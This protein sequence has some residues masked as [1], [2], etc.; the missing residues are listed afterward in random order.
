MSKKRV[1]SVKM[2]VCRMVTRDDGTKRWTNVFITVPYRVLK[3]ARKLRVIS[4]TS[5]ADYIKEKM[6]CTYGQAY[7]FVTQ[8][9]SEPEGDE[10]DRDS[11]RY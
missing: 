1:K 6:S 10:D 5:A 2:E 11:R 3:R 7:D 8:L 9:S 4:M